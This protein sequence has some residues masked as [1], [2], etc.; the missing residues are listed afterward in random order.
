MRDRFTSTLLLLLLSRA[1]AKAILR[2]AATL[3]DREAA[4]LQGDPNCG[5]LNQLACY[6]T[7]AAG[8][9]VHSCFSDGKPT[10]G[11][12][13]MTADALYTCQVCGGPE[14]PACE[15]TNDNEA[16]ATSPCEQGLTHWCLGEGFE[17]VAS[18]D[19]LWKCEATATVPV[20]LADQKKPTPTVVG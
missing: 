12:V 6:S 18:P 2:E 20:V 17:A 9:E 4:T 1:H 16:V 10:I 7:D 8:N 5:G 15:C 3:Q 14:G 11:A 19:G 13:Q